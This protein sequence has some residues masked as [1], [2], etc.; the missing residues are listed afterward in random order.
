MTRFL[1][2]NTD[3]SSYLIEKPNIKRFHSTQENNYGYIFSIGDFALVLYG[4]D[5]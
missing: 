1:V 4:F 5:Y 3:K 2:A